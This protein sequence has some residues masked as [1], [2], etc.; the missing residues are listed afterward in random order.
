M[1]Q[2]HKYHPAPHTEYAEH[3]EPWYCR[4]I[5]G[6]LKS[7]LT[8]GKKIRRM[9][10][11]SQSSHVVEIPREA[12]CG[13]CYENNW[14][15]FVPASDAVAERARG[16][17]YKTKSCMTCYGP[18]PLPCSHDHDMVAAGRADARDPATMGTGQQRPQRW[19]RAH[20][21][22]WT[23]GEYW[24]AGEGSGGGG[25]G[26]GAWQGETG[27][28]GGSADYG[29]GYAAPGFDPQETPGVGPANSAP[30]SNPADFNR[31]FPDLAALAEKLNKEAEAAQASSTAIPAHISPP[32]I[33]LQEIPPASPIHQTPPAGPLHRTPPEIPLHEI[34]PGSPPPEL[35]PATPHLSHRAL[36]T[37]SLFFHP[38]DFIGTV[39][40][41][42]IT[43][44][45]AEP[46][47]GIRSQLQ[48]VSYERANLPRSP[49]RRRITWG[50]RE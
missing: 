49:K 34:P 14:P 21:E 12:A 36:P 19:P 38:R 48:Q 50:G 8:H 9:H 31:E 47:R 24:N 13:R 40:S 25:A 2:E 20:R 28:D 46:P 1:K 11:L 32:G 39:Y 33:P 3:P 44:L 30:S 15:C 41:H 42:G 35:P 23:G 4:T 6:R 26:G 37:S 7:Y 5:N 16:V 18:R 29:Y 22:G 17:N 10:V 45:F 27:Q 43:F